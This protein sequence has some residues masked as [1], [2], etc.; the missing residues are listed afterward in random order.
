MRVVLCLLASILLTSPVVAAPLCEG[1]TIEMNPFGPDAA[2]GP[3]RITLNPWFMRRWS[4]AAQRFII[5][6]ECAH[7]TGDAGHAYYL[8]LYDEKK[9]DLRAF[10][11]AYAEGWLTRRTIRAICRSMEDDPASETHPSSKSRCEALKRRYRE[12]RRGEWTLQS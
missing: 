1:V 3:G 7:A 5:Y 11:R 8:S 2:A 4:K 10:Q 12:A 9:A 6:H